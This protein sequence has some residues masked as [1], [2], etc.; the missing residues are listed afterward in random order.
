MQIWGISVFDK[1]QYKNYLLNIK[2]IKMSKYNKIYSLIIFKA[3]V[4]YNTNKA[5]LG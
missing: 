2:L 3:S 5:D 4:M 1:T